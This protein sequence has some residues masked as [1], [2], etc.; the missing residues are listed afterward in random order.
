MKIDFYYY[1]SSNAEWAEKAKEVYLKKISPFCKFSLKQIKSKSN[2]RDN[3]DQKLLSEQKQL[4]DLIDPSDF[5]ILFDEKGKAFQNSIDL[6]KAIVKAIESGKS[7]LVFVIG[8]PYGF[9]EEVKN[10]AQLRVSL[11]GL[12]MNH[13]VALIMSLEQIYR[14]FTIWKGIPYHNE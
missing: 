4:F 14:S 9:S 12:T 11:S 5:L 8:G 2:K 6:S 3:K 7:R 1:H 13:H 10:R